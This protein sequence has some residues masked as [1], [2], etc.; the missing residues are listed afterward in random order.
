LTDEEEQEHFDRK[1]KAVASDAGCCLLELFIA[2]TVVV[3]L[4]AFPAGLLLR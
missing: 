1:A 2:A 4:L 3:A